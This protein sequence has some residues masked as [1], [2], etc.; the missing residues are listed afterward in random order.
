MLYVK[1]LHAKS[2]RRIF[3]A[4]FIKKSNSNIENSD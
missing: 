1:M 2:I 4:D 3:N